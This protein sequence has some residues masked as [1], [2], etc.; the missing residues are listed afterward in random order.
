MEVAVSCE[1]VTIPAAYTYTPAVHTATVASLQTSAA[2][3]VL[4]D[5]RFRHSVVF[6]CGIQ[7]LRLL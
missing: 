4:A 7:S 3:S 5:I 6:C 1:M 2:H